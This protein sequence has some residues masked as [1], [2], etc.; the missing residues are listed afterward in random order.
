MRKDL[1]QHVDNPANV[2]Q[3]LLLA[4]K[5]NVILMQ[6]LEVS[7]VSGIPIVIA[8]SRAHNRGLIAGTRGIRCGFG[9]CRH[10][11]VICEAGAAQER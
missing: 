9:G 10:T 2:A 11:R 7:H 3:H 4:D 1:P 8:R 6:R 5:T